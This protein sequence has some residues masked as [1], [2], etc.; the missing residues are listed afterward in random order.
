MDSDSEGSICEKG[1]GE[2]EDAMSLGSSTPDTEYVYEET[3][4]CAQATNCECC[5]D[6]PDADY[7]ESSSSDESD[8]SN[9]ENEEIESSMDGDSEDS[10]SVTSDE[11]PATLSIRILFA[12]FVGSLCFRRHLRG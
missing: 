8:K 12:R 1:S 4:G 3:S 11:N 5:V 7:P 6:P 9:D 2:S 10:D